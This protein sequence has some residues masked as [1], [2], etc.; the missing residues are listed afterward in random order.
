VAWVPASGAKRMA[1]MLQGRSDWCISRQRAWGLPIPVLYYAD[2]GA[3]PG[4]GY[5]RRRP[6]VVCAPRAPTQRGRAGAPLM[7]EETI[8]H[9]ADVVAAKGSDAFWTAPIEELLPERLRGEAPRLARQLETLD[10][11]FDSGASW[12]AVLEAR[13]G[14]RFPA[15]VYLEGSDQHRGWFQSSLLTAVAARGAAPYRA[16]VTHGFALDEKARA[17]VPPAAPRRRHS[18]ARDG[19]GVG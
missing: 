9:M 10:V 7:T 4:P 3:P 18:G 12:A 14:L 16:V 6:G 15:D 13:P 5:S 11:W 8:A 2:T 1:S 17:P 19:P